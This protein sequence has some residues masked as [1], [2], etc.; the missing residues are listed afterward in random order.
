MELVVVLLEK[1]PLFLRVHP[2]HLV[3]QPHVLV[4]Q[5][6]EP[7]EE[8]LEA[9]KQCTTS[10]LPEHRSNMGLVGPPAFF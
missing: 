6:L 4:L 3:T 5:Y 9:F 2:L 7:L 10:L 8:P 1:M